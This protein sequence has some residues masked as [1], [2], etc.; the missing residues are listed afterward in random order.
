MTGATPLYV[1]YLR[2]GIAM[3]DSQDNLLQAVHASMFERTDEDSYP[4]ICNLHDLVDS[5]S[6]HNCLGCNFAEIVKSIEA[7]AH[8]FSNFSD[9]KT[10]KITY[11]LWLYLLT[12]RMQEILKLISFP[13]ELKTQKFPYF[14]LVKRWG[15]FFKHP[16]AFFLT[17]HAEYV[18]NSEKVG[19]LIDDTFIN[20]YY[21]GDKHNQHLYD[22]LTNKENVVV[23]LPNLVTLTK[24]LGDELAY[25]SEV[26]RSNPIYSEIV[27][28]K[29]ILKGYFSTETSDT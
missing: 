15:N 10:A 7:I 25:L 29:S 17:H 4:T 14:N 21:S 20:R 19:T 13:E 11:I 26:I 28:N 3:N 16:K 1:T 5:E 2:L 6:S 24:A 9:E 8:D 27:T 18:E 12:E 22:R 23:Q